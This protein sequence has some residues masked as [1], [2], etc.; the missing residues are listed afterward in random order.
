MPRA[1]WNGYVLAESD[2]TIMVEGN[3]YFPREALRDEFFTVSDKRT[4]CAWKGQA[5]YFDVTV[6]GVTNRN[7][8]WTYPEPKPKA[9][10]IKDYVAFWGGVKVLP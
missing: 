10:H 5:T 8:A 4:T 3:H 9:K 1:L 7:A 6:D 2:D